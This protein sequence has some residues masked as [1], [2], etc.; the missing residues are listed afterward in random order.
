MLRVTR[1]CAIPL[2]ELQWRFHA[3]GGPGGQHANRSSTAV[4]VR[5]D[6]V[7]SRALGPRQRA[8]LLARHGT[9]VVARAS[10]RR[11]QLRNREAALERLRARIAE[12]LRSERP[13]VPTRPTR[14]AEAARV[15]RKRRH[16]ARKRERRRAV[17][18][19]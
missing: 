1:T 5:F 7:A 10:E 4:E 8:R 17:D 15:E 18:D 19:E 14:G 13:R 3:A 16:G 12:A 9:H 2:D 6:V 11:S